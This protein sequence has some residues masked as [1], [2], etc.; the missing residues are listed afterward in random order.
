DEAAEIIQ[1]IPLLDSCEDKIS[2]NLVAAKA[3][4]EQARQIAARCPCRGADGGAKARLLGKLDELLRRIATTEGALQDTEE[5]VHKH[6]KERN[7]FSARR[8]LYEAKFPSEDPR[9]PRLDSDLGLQEAQV[10]RLIQ[11]ADTLILSNPKRALRLYDQARR[12][13]R[14]LPKPA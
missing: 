3:A 6:M 11:E 7:L 13:N 12:L 8:V 14:E 4:C 10:A 1:V 2:K 5:S 9:L